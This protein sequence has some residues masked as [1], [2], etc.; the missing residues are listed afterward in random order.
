M[1]HQ[2]QMSEINALM[3]TLQDVSKSA[4]AADMSEQHGDQDALRY[5]QTCAYVRRHPKGS[6]SQTS[7]AKLSED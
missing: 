2:Q 4:G 7:L 5:E 1:I 6:Q 3:Q